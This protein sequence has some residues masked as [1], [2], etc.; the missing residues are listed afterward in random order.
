MTAD[1]TGHEALYIVAPDT[2]VDTPSHE[3]HELH[4]PNVSLRGDLTGRRGFFDC[5]KAEK[6]LGWSH[7]AD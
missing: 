4:Y 5:T 6:L 1:F 7:D 2:M 3:L